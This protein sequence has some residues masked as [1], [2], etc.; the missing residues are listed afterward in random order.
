MAFF[1]NQSQH[2]TGFPSQQVQDVLVVLKFD[3]FPHDVLFQVLLLLQLEDVAH[4]ELL[5][6]LV[7]KINAQLLEAVQRQDDICSDL[8]NCRAVIR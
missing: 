2:V 6:L 4:K 1:I 5:Q 7:G 3:V 8:R